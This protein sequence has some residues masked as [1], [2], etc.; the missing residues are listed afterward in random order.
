MC[1]AL[2]FDHPGLHIVSLAMF[3]DVRCHGVWY[4][5][6]GWKVQAGPH[7]RILSGGDINI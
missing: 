7:R 3:F 6:T 4:R 5:N 1:P 2:S